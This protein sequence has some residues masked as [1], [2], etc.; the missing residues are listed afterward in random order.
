MVDR[1]KRRVAIAA[2]LMLALL[3]T[4]ASADVVVVASAD[5]PLESLT[6]RQLADVFLGRRDRLPGGHPIAPVEQS[7]SSPARETFYRDYLGRSAA[8]VQAHWSKLVFTGRGRPPRSA[9]DDAGVAEIVADD[10][11]AIGYLDRRFVDERLRVVR[12]EP[13]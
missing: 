11:H 13:G 1:P 2:G 3:A 7:G 5:S 4:G 8:Q 9:K 10:P 6:P 12:I